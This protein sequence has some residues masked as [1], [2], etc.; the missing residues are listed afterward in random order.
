MTIVWLS[1]PGSEQAGT[2]L[3]EVLTGGA[4]A[5]GPGAGAALAGWASIISATGRPH[6]I[7]SPFAQRA[8]RA[9]NANDETLSPPPGT[10]PWRPLQ[11]P[12]EPPPPASAAAGCPGRQRSLS[13]RQGP[14][15]GQSVRGT[16]ESKGKAE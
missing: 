15:E 10:S 5:A 4:V 13:Q 1:P 6:T 2:A 3:D 14:P 12:F 7:S 8:C 11:G 16:A 9:M